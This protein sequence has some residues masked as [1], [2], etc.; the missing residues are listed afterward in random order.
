MNGNIRGTLTDKPGQ[1]FTSVRVDDP[2]LV[3]DLDEHKISYTGS[4]ESKLIGILLAWIIPIGIFFL[5]SHFF[6][7][8]MGPGMGVMSFSKNKAKIF[9]E[10]ETKISFADV[11]DIDEAKEELQE[12]VEFLTNPKKFQRLGGRIPKGVL[13][14]F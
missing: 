7:K 1:E 5:I 6:M 11:A 3:K 14:P 13:L 12:I 4:H 10:S 2:G 9:A 8:K